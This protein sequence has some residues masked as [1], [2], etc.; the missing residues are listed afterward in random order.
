M[1]KHCRILKK[2]T[3][4][5][6]CGNVLETIQQNNSKKKKG[7]KSQRFNQREIKWSKGG[8]V[9]WEPNNLG[10]PAKRAAAPPLASLHK[11]C[12]MSATSGQLLPA[13]LSEGADR[14]EPE[15][16]SYDTKGFNLIPLETL[17][18]ARQDLDLVVLLLLDRTAPLRLIVCDSVQPPPSCERIA[19]LSRNFL[20]K[21]VSLAVLVA[22]FPLSKHW[23]DVVTVQ[24]QIY[25]ALWF[26]LLPRHS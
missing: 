10:P 23:A 13:G 25:L 12:A 21:G 26:L 15:S 11:G 7:C 6:L 24:T 4:K 16:V 1:K 2:K 19:S 8:E 18:T 5:G 22:L 9:A 17:H 3:C 20:F 14:S